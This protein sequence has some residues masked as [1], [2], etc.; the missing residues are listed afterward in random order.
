MKISTATIVSPLELLYLREWV[1]HHLNLGITDFYMGL[2]DF[3]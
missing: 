3:T 1:C 2:N